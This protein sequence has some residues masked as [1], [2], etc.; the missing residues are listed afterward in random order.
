MFFSVDLLSVK[1]GKFGTIWLLATTKDRKAVVKKKMKRTELLRTNMSQLCAELTRMFPAQGKD[2]RRRNRSIQRAGGVGGSV[3]VVV[4]GG[5]H[6]NHG[7]H[8]STGG[9][10]GV[11]QSISCVE[12]AHCVPLYRAVTDHLLPG[13]VGVPTHI[14][15]D[16]EPIIRF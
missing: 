15:A 10:G 11:L 1:G 6:T 2:R 5:V 7:V 9:A 12:G 16:H 3:V 14:H 4:V 8:L 13:L